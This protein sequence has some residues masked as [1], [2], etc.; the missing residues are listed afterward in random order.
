VHIKKENVQQAVHEFTTKFSELLGTYKSKKL[1]PVNSPLEI[2]VTAL[3]T[4]SN[5]AAQN[6]ERPVISGLAAGSD[7][8]AN[9][10][11]VAVWF[12]VL[13]LPGTPASDQFYADLETWIYQNYSGTYARVLPEWSKGWAYSSQGAWT[14]T[15]VFDFIRQAMIS[16]RESNDDWNWAV[17]TLQKYDAGKLF[18]NPMLE[19]LFVPLTLAAKA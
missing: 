7:D 16:G 19:A 17:A 4:P 12:D 5:V 18:S 14:N 1:Y 15:Q 3:D 6:A 11:D 8:V 13:T 2:R 9:G 10:W